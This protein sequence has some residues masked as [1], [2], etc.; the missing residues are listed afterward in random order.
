MGRRDT[1]GLEG[2]QRPACAEL[3]EVD[4]QEALHGPLRVDAECPGGFRCVRIDDEGDG[5][6]PCPPALRTALNDGQ[7]ARAAG[8]RLGAGPGRPPATGRASPL[9]K[10]AR[11]RGGGGRA[12]GGG[13]RASRRRARASRPA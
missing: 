3:L 11:P 12:R 6:V 8:L 9:G 4:T 1:C 5:T 2:S 7:A 10:R 13:R